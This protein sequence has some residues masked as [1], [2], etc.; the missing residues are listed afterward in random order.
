MAQVINTNM[1]SIMAQRNLN[2]AQ[3]ANETA[4]QRLSSG[5][6]INSAKDDAAGLAIST[7]FDAQIRGTN[8]GIR[9]ANDGISLAQTA[10]GALGAVNDNLQRMRELAVQ[11][12]NGTLNET[13]RAALQQEVSSLVSEVDRTVRDTNFNGTKLLDGSFDGVNFQIGANSGQTVGVTVG[14]MSTNV[15]GA[16][17]SAGA[18]AYGNNVSLAKGDAVVNGVVIGPSFREDDKA[19]F[20]DKANS[21]IAKAAAFNLHSDETGVRAEVDVNRV[22]GGNMANRTTATA[23]S[24]AIAINGVTVTIGIGGQDA[25][26]DRESVVAAINAKS[27]LTGVVAINTGD[28][29]TGVILEAADG[30]NITLGIATDVGTINSGASAATALG[31]NQNMFAGAAATLDNSASYATAN[32]HVGGYTLRSVDGRDI[33]V[34]SATNNIANAGLVEDTYEKGVSSVSNTLA[35]KSVGGASLPTAS[36]AFGTSNDLLTGDLV[37]NNTSIAAT[38][39]TDDTA[40]IAG[41]AGSAIALAAAIN[42]S[43][44]QTGVTAEVDENVMLGGTMSLA[45]AGATAAGSFSL[46]GVQIQFSQTSDTGVRRQDVVAQINQVS[47]QTGVTAIDTGEDSKG[48]QLVAADGRNIVLDATGTTD[49]AGLQAATGIVGSA[50]GT[51]VVSITK[52]TVTLKAAQDITVEAGTNGAAGLANSAFKAGTYG[53]SEGGQALK[54]IDISTV[55][56]ANKALEAIDNAISSVAQ[57]RGDLGAFQ[58]RMES[59][60]RTQE[61]SSENLTGANSRIRDADFASETAELSRTQVLQQAGVSVLAQANQRPQSV[62]SL[63]G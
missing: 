34:K 62:L 41:N 15:L 48:I 12:A 23:A 27:D 49:M 28:D 31:L 11:A 17:E 58:N 59:T 56:G 6:R 35:N 42:R 60:I 63:L 4:L 55:A 24:A 13:D 36:T 37:I 9:N 30:R 61:V 3:K 57:V 16:A 50:T 14:N 51:D 1:A 40:S 7:R 39:A 22:E 33:E 43:S 52:S 45:T 18:S 46:N 32:T 19:S 54:D 8:M 10:E 26:A 25:E 38:R 5:M 44:E 20:A 21:A 53:Q 29:A 47:A 2:N